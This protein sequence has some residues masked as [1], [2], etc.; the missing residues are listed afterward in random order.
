MKLFNQF[1]EKYREEGSSLPKII[2]GSAFALVTL[3][4]VL[5]IFFVG[6]YSYFPRS[7]EIKK[8]LKE[9]KVEFEAATDLLKQ[10][11]LEWDYAMGT[12]LRL[13]DEGEIHV[14]ED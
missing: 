10:R 6:E 11:S 9:A 13:G 4:Y 8:D 14:V 2:F 1:S 12:G 5:T 7:M 3:Y